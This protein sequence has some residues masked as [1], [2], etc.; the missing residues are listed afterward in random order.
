MT[1]CNALYMSEYKKAR[2]LKNKPSYIPLARRYVCALEIKWILIFYNNFIATSTVYYMKLSF[3]P[4]SISSSSDVLLTR[5]THLACSYVMVLLLVCIINI[6]WRS[7]HK[8]RKICNDQFTR[9]LHIITVSWYLLTTFQIQAFFFKSLYTV[10]CHKLCCRVTK[11][12]IPKGV[13]S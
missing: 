1:L 8:E 13:I 10:C 11:M 7:K 6:C 4:D 12:Q 9:C 2:M 5:Y 3:K